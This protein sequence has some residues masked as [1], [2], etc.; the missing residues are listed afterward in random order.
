MLM[1]L[2]FNMPH[3]SAHHRVRQNWLDGKKQKK[4]IKKFV[5]FFAIVEPIMTLPQIY[6][7]WIRHQAA[8]VSA[9]TWLFYAVASTVW[10]LYA[11][12]IKDKPLIISSS[13]WF[14]MELMVIFGV[15]I[16]V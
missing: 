5:L 1:L 2:F 3:H 4:F 13:I 14:A 15:V 16:Y 8:G 7:I 9:L 10:L 12:Q 11:L 6:E